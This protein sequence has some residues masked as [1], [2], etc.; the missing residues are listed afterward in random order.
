MDEVRNIGR[1]IECDDEITDELEEYYI[2]EDG[3]CFCCIECLLEHYG[4]TKI[5]I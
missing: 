3:E 5:E 2:T 1:C 4:I